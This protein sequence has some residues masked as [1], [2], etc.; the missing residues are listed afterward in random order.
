MW[1]ATLSGILPPSILL[2]ASVGSF[3]SGHPSSGVVARRVREAGKSHYFART[4]VGL[5][6]A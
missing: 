6:V 1:E 5:P 2:A 3:L 4:T